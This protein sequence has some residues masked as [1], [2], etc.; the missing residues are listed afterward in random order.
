M[1][2]TQKMLSPAAI[3][4]ILRTMFLGAILLFPT[5]PAAALDAGKVAAQPE[6]MPAIGETS[7]PEAIMSEEKTPAINPKPG[8]TGD[9]SPTLAVMTL[10]DAPWPTFRQNLQ[11]TGLSPC[12]G[13]QNPSEKKINIILDTKPDRSGTTT[14]SNPSLAEMA[15]FTWFKAQKMTESCMPS[16][17]TGLSNGPSRWDSSAHPR[18]LWPRTAPFMSAPRGA[19]AAIFLLSTPTA[20]KNGAIKSAVG[21]C[22]HPPR[23]PTAPFMWVLPAASYM[24]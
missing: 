2:I 17:P 20:L 8:L 4:I 11:H 7:V 3:N 24:P 13:P 23:P 5:V 6:E 1:T 9:N 16:S 15:L 10:P 12:R 22:P 18:P 19:A 21:R 14:E